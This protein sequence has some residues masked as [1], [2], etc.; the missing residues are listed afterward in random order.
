MNT[1]RFAA[2]L[3][4]AL[5]ATAPAHARGGWDGNGTSTNGVA[6]GVLP[7]GATQAVLVIAIELPAR[8]Q[9]GQ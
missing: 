3:S 8:T 1:L 2:A 9:A 7:A 4:L 6:Q 5:L